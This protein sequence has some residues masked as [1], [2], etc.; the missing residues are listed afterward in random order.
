MNTI[1]QKSLLFI[2][3]GLIIVVLTLVGY[4]HFFTPKI[5]FVRTLELVYGYNG[6]K[7]AHN[8]YKVQSEAWQANIDTLHQR[9]QTKARIYED[10]KNTSSNQ[11][12]AETEQELMR[13]QQ[14]I[15]KYTS[16]IN[17]QAQ[18]KDAKITEA[19]LSQINSF[20][21][22]YAK[23]KGYDIVL[24]AQ[25]DGGLLF[26]TNYYDI[27]DDVLKEL[28]KQYKYVPVKK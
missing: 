9:Y 5:V 4:I 13:M 26:G 27:T 2:S 1:P 19:I 3:A 16:A 10:S 22:T 8:E 7:E 17:E 25:G 12:K 24:G 14:D 21:E 6:M 20:V 18:E 28:N 11:E 15:Q 23:D